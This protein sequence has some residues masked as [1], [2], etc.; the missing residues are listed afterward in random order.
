MSL[1]KNRI[2]TIDMK[3]LKNGAAETTQWFEKPGN[4]ESQSLQK[5]LYE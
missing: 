1:Y 4:E 5:F 2:F 3:A